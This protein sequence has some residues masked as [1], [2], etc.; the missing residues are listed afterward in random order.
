[1]FIEQVLKIK[2]KIINAF[3]ILGSSLKKRKLIWKGYKI[4]STAYIG[5]RSSIAGNFIRI[6]KYVTIVSDAKFFGS[7]TIGD[8]C[9]IAARCKILTV[10]HD[11]FRSNALPYGTDYINKPVIIG[12]NVWIGNDV[13]II[14]GVTIEEGAVIA[15]GAVVTKNIPKCAVVGG[16]PAK[17][18]KYREQE[19]YQKLKASSKYLNFIRGHNVRVKKKD[20]NIALLIFN[21]YGIVNEFELNELLPEKRAATLYQLSLVI[22]GAKFELVDSNYYRLIRVSEK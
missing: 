4:D 3:S 22:T 5:P 21:K 9:I 8:H 12:N 17:I 18:I 7:I 14:P 16:N 1:M 19:H 13:I 10:S 15:T 2:G 11:Y 6:G 20:M